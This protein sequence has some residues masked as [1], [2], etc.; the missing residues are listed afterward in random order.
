MIFFSSVEIIRES[1]YSSP[2]HLCIQP[3][4]TYKVSERRERGCARER[5]TIEKK[6]RSSDRGW[7][8]RE[9]VLKYSRG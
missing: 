9:I 4:K 1:L 5:E 3:P 8:E 2:V 7:R 6:E